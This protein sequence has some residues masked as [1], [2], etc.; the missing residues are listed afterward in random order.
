MT[1]L[2][3]CAPLARPTQVRTILDAA[4]SEAKFHSACKCS[5]RRALLSPQVRTILDAA[6]S[7]AKFHSAPL[8]LQFSSLSS[9]GTKPEWLVELVRSFCGTRPTP[10][11]IEVVFPTQAQV[12]ES[13]EGCYACEVHASAHHG[14]LLS[15]QVG[16]SLEGWYAGN[17]IPCEVQNVER[18]QAS[19]LPIA[20]D[21][22]PLHACAHHGASSLPTL[23]L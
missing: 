4:P 22:L 13:L 7:E 9:P 5:P 23:R 8:V 2:I 10:S 15:P 20:S 6:P 16:E 3:A 17:S 21:D 1:S 18:L 12:G 14:A 19:D 11:A